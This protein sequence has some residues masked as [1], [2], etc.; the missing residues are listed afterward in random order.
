LAST[1]TAAPTPTGVPTTKPATPFVALVRPDFAR[2]VVAL[3]LHTTPGAKVHITFSI[4][5]MLAG[6]SVHT[7]FS[8]THDG[9]TNARGLFV[10]SLKIHFPAHTPGEA[11]LTIGATSGGTTQ[12]VKRTYRYRVYE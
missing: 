5:N 7:V 10:Y 2:D 3:A 9:L 4:T 8:A 12:T 1:P 6:G 11:S